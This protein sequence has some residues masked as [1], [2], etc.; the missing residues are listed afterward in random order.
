MYDTI[1]T[2]TWLSLSIAGIILVIGLFIMLSKPKEKIV[3][4][5][6]KAKKKKLDLTSLDKNEKK[7]IEKALD[8]LNPKNLVRLSV[9]KT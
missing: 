3:V 1:K 9:K 4:K 2:Q 7:A 6:L 5:T 8:Y